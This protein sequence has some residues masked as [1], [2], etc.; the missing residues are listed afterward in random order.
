[1]FL[2]KKLVKLQKYR[3][4]KLRSAERGWG[5][6]QGPMNTPLA[7]VTSDLTWSGSDLVS[8]VVIGS[9][10]R[11][12]AAQ[13]N[14]SDKYICIARNSLSRILVGAELTVQGVYGPVN[15][16]GKPRPLAGDYQW[17]TLANAN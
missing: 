12:V 17:R 3:H 11:I 2:K 10:Y 7:T 6:A 5:Q 14:D 16:H 1:M 9:R 4:Q 13:L 15:R 8:C